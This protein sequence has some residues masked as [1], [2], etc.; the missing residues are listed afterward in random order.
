M[1]LGY[2]KEENIEDCFFT[3]PL[4]NYNNQKKHSNN[5]NNQRKITYEYKP[6]KKS[7]EKQT[8]NKPISR[9]DRSLNLPP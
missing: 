7:E 4:Q 3:H 1:E 6:T 9:S 2:C 5:R 8:E